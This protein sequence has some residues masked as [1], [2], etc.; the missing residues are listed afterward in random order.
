ML[1]RR[2]GKRYLRALL[3]EILIS[4]ATMEISV[5]VPQK[6]KNTTIF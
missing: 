6:A 3:V 2:Q 1:E 4:T 5:E